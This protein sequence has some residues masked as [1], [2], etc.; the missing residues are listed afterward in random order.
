M[1][2]DQQQLVQRQKGITPTGVAGALAP[3][4]VL[5]G[6]NRM[7]SYQI[8]VL[9]LITVFLVQILSIA[10]KTGSL[11]KRITVSVVNPSPAAAPSVGRIQSESEPKQEKVQIVDI[12]EP[13]QVAAVQEVKRTQQRQPQVLPSQIDVVDL[14]EKLPKVSASRVVAEHPLY[15]NST[16]DAC[17][18]HF[19]SILDP[20]QLAHLPNR[21]ESEAVIAPLPLSQWEQ[22]LSTDNLQVVKHPTIP[23]LYALSA[24]YPDIPLRNLWE[25]LIDIRRR[26]S[27]DTMTSMT[28]DLDSIGMEE[29][30]GA[31]SR[32]ATITYL[33][34]KGMFPVKANDM[35]MLSVNARLMPTDGP[36]RLVCATTS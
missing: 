26:P 24:V 8:A 7:P 31:I 1:A 28:E 3:I 18:R 19:L 22:M 36:V 27:W 33:A 16:I 34:T 23:H 12:S 35:V 5:L 10:L 4:L 11:S 9:Q 6:S 13:E 32:Q 14:E 20:S 17:L 29:Q 30:G 15:S 21:S 25:L 2:S